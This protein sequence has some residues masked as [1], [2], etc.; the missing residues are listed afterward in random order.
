MNVGVRKI[1]ERQLP[2][3]MTPMIDIVFQL[4][5]FFLV[6]AQLSQ[7]SRADLELP[8]EAGETIEESIEAGMIVNVLASGDLEIAGELVTMEDFDRT[9]RALVVEAGDSI[10]TLR[11][12]VRADRRAPTAALNRVL[13]TLQK[14]GVPSVRIATAPRN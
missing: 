8:Q 13:S 10:S 7:H 3:D 12:L 11:P 9:S 6:T 2:V 5:I 14:A 1:S 4:L